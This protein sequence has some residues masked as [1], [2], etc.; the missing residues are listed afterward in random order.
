MTGITQ[1]LRDEHKELFPHVESLRLAG[2][3]LTESFDPSTSEKID[4]A[5]NFLTQHLI[6]HAQAEDKALYPVVQ[7][8]MGATRATATMSRDHVEVG[9]LTDE[10]ARLRSEYVS[11]NTGSEQVQGLRRV[12]YGLYALVKV[13]FAKEEE[14]YLP[15]LDE[16]LTQ[17]EA[18]AMFEAMES[19]ANDAKEHLA[20]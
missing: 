8:V 17:A 9:R 10:L 5:Y 2:D 13:H 4:E 20:T 1:P 18:D 3:A 14:I 15:L 7:K 19:A 12:L 11:Q 6:P 16:N